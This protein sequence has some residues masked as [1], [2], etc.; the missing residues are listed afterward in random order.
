MIVESITTKQHAST[1]KWIAKCYSK[2]IG[3]LEQ[4]GETE[5]KALDNLINHVKVQGEEWPPIE[6]VE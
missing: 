6:Y 1:G 4:W 3:T 5:L 2:R